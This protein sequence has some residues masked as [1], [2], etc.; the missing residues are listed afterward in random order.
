MN[1]E[2][3]PTTEV[4]TQPQPSFARVLVRYAALVLDSL[5]LV[6]PYLL[7]VFILTFLSIGKLKPLLN[8][9]FL[10]ISW[11]YNIFFITKNGATLGKRF[12]KLKVVRIDQT[13][14][15]LGKVILRETVGKFVS[16]LVFSLGYFWAIFDGKK[17]AWHDKIAGTYVIYTDGLSKRRKAIAYIV[18]LFLPGLALLGI[19][20]SILLVT[21]NPIKQIN[22]ARDTQRKS[23]IIHLQQAVEFY[24]AENGVYPVNLFG[25]S[26]WISTVPKDPETE[27]DYIYYATG[28]GKNYILRATLSAGKVYE[29]RGKNESPPSSP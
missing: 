12:F 9:V 24:Y 14:V 13:P 21:I 16:S 7:A 11:C 26:K 22:R 8:F 10:P 20:A 1:E 23:D 5:V 19:V 25:L 27:K 29:V 28:G 15:S 17:Q 18:A 2:V 6:I 4:P 3:T